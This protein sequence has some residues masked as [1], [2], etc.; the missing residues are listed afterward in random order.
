MA[1][2]VVERLRG[3]LDGDGLGAIIEIALAGALFAAVVAA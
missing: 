3:G 1:V 2:L